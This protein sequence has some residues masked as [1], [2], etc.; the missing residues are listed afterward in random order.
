MPSAGRSV[1]TPACAQ[2]RDVDCM[3]GCLLLHL[4]GIVLTDGEVRKQFV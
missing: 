2:H 4:A 3:G 1:F